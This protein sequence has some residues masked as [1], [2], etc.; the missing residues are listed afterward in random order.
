MWTESASGP[1]Q[2][3][4]LVPGHAY[5]VIS[6][7]EKKGIRLLNIRNPWGQFEWDGDWS[8]N[9]DKWTEEMKIAFN[10]VLED[11]D[12]TFWMSFE[13]FTSRFDSLDV[14]RV[15]NWDELRVR[16]RFIRYTDLNDPDNEV[17]V[18]K[19]F[20]ALEVPTKTHIIIGLH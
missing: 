19:W 20:Y 9:S 7:V 5:S 10:P 4:G 16:G 11:T 8:D 3:G 18:S 15:S 2:K 14:C 1:D 6:A 12:G 17:V 13:D